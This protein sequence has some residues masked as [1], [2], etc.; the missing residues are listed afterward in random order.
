MEK[1]KLGRIITRGKNKKNFKSKMR[2]ATSM[3]V[4]KLS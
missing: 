2:K 3:K 4:E 1:M